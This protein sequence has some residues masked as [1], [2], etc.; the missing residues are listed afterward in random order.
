MSMKKLGLLGL[1]AVM[2]MSVV[3]VAGVA[4][5]SAAEPEYLVLF[6]CK[7]VTAGTGFWLESV[8]G[9]CKKID[10]PAAGNFEPTAGT[11]KVVAAGEKIPFTSTS[12]VKV[13]KTLVLGTLVEVRCEK[14]TNTGNITGPRQDEVTVTFEGCSFVGG[15]ECQNQGTGT[16]RI[17]T[18]LLS[19]LLVWLKEPE[20][21]VG[22]ALSAKE[23]ALA[24][25]VCVTPFGEVTVE[26]TESVLGEIT[27]VNTPAG[28]FELE[29]KCVEV[30]GEHEQAWRFY[31][32]PPGTLVE[33]KLLANGEEACEEEVTNDII[34][35]SEPVEIMG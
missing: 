20:L 18:K 26:V 16:K 7:R 34:T 24:T 3:A 9:L 4:G 6:E 33:D 22:L 11:G 13:L 27:P 1:L 25:F 30:E 17:V 19:S 21:L 35:M 31:E 23:G 32:E 28:Q 5:A 29:L 2:A 10:L 14:D 15:G 12:G 8:G